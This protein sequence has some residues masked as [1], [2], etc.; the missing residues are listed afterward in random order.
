[1]TLVAARWSARHPW[2][3]IGGWVVF[4]AACL[5]AGRLVAANPAESRDYWIGE[6]G[7]AEAM[8]EGAGLFQP[9]VDKV[10]ITSRR[11]DLNMAE[12]RSA[13]ADLAQR[14]T[15]N[16]AVAEVGRA[17]TSSDGAA[18]MVPI[19][20]RGELK[21]AKRGV[22]SVK[23]DVAVVQASH[24]SLLLAQTG[25][26][27]ISV[28]VETQLGADLRRAELIT[29]PITLVILFVVFGSIVAAGLPLIL[30]L[31][32]IAASFGI[33]PLTTYLF[34]DVGGAVAN[35]ILMM[36]MAVGVDYSLLYVKRVREE[37]LLD[38]ERAGYEGAVN[39]AAA[40][41]GRAI[42]LSAFAVMASLFGL[43]AA[44]DVVSTSI[45]TGSI[46]VVL[47]AMIG[48]LTVLPALLTKL[49]RFSGRWQKKQVEISQPPVAQRIW[50]AILKPVMARPALSLV[51]AIGL[52]V[53]LALPV[54]NLRLSVEGVDTFPR[55]IPAVA[56]YDR[57]TQKFPDQGVAHLV[58]VRAHPSQSREVAQA[59]AALAR[60]AQMTS[61][62]AA[63]LTP[64]IRISADARVTTL[65]TPITKGANS[66][67]GALSL[68]A[69]RGQL[70]PAFIGGIPGAEYAVS[71][72]V[73]RSLDY[74]RHQAEHLPL[75]VG[76]V[77]LVTFVIMATAF[78]SLVIGVIG[79]LLNLLSAA[80]ALGALVALF[81][82]GWAESL[83]GL[84]PGGFVGS[85]I[86]MFLF[87]ILFGLSMDYQVFVLSR[88]REAVLEGK[89]V[90]DA[91]YQGVTS[92]AGVVTSAAIIMISVFASFMFVGLQ[93][94]K[95]I[96]F[97][98]AF[99]VFV[100]AFVIRILV[101][102]AALILLG[103]ICWRS[104]PASSVASKS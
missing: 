31:T 96:G 99:A 50:P 2:L 33:Y 78:R 95:Q 18:V 93:E 37:R 83:F 81:Q 63:N 91:I 47:I 101:L 64:R 59:L 28:G 87:V 49:G 11:G 8:A 23:A 20:M 53:I 26:A 103:E 102:P 55:S 10:L 27:S 97:G 60:Q 76:G 75:V 52:I 82:Y 86:P 4:V 66:P 25:G 17:T 98:L 90:R 58:V 43:Y 74:V 16:P 12:A 68:Q 22:A 35:I 40:T 92:S 24:P 84:P 38:D 80:A 42:V 6:A 94:L 65:E 69:L 7:R 21:V 15:A 51:A 13:R 61:P 54:A 14:L 29:L 56:A 44:D 104:A 34:P 30:A 79:C 32:A 39:R 57:L 85:R 73:A 100:D 5:F 88:I 70:V 3:A 9:V 77:L 1:M 36:G 19:V 71:G 46:L 62:F 48:S 41:A 45:A 67:D 72:Q 89:N